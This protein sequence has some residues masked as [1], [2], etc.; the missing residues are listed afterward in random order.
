MALL[1]LAVLF[2]CSQNGKEAEGHEIKSEDANPAYKAAV[3][4]TAVIT[5][6]TFEQIPMEMQG[7]NAVFVADTAYSLPQYVFAS[8]RES[9]AFVRLNNKLTELR[10][11]KRTNN[12]KQ[13][14]NELYEGD[15][16]EVEV[17]ISPV[18]KTGNNEWTH[19]GILVIRKEGQQEDIDI[20]GKVGC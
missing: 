4:E 3:I 14:I 8:N 2:S 20:T 18:K 11:V 1:S 5:L 15:G 9:M 19:K 17:K 10:L 6:K 13:T 12:D 16:M 7:C